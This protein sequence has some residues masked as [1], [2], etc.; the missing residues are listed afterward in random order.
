MDVIS[1]SPL[2]GLGVLV[3]TVPV[4]SSPANFRRPFG[5]EIRKIFFL[6]SME[7][8]ITFDQK[9]AIGLS[10]DPVPPTTAIGAA[11]NRNSQ[12]LRAAQA[13]LKASRSQLSKI[14]TPIATSTN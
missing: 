12:R 6:K 1:L 4:I 7:L 11:V 5:T 13:S 8:P 10:G 9:V 2:Q 14:Y 3:A